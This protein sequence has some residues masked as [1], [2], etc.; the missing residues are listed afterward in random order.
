MWNGLEVRVLEAGYCTHPGFMVHP[1]SGLAPRQFPAL[2][3]LGRDPE[4]GVFL[5]DTGY[6]K[7]FHQATEAFPE[8]LYRWATP[9]YLEAHQSVA[10]QL[11]LLDLH[12]DQVDH[13]LLSHFHADHVAAC[14]DFPNATVHCPR[15]GYEE[16]RDAGRLG[17]VLKGY[18]PALMP[19][20]PLSAVEDFPLDVG[21]LLGLEPVGLK[22]AS[23]L[24]SE[25]IYLVELP[26]HARGHFGLLLLTHPCH[27]FFLADA[28]WH[29][30]ALADG[31]D[32]HP[33]ATLLF[34]DR[35][36]YRE[37]LETLRSLYR[38]LHPRV[39]FV[40]SHCS[41]LVRAMVADG[42]LKLPPPR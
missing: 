21:P 38:Q 2:V 20:Q 5:F 22:A 42:W 25:Q 4:R 29:K 37:T 1:G 15:A 24:G 7:R 14:D 39:Q 26:G 33:L 9:C 16:C 35:K 30:A 36:A 18:L 28:C 11:D 3:V 41:D 12:P 40:P 13:L 32:V 31:V 27:L 10:E 19:T 23:W 6:G 17:G 8:R 34:H